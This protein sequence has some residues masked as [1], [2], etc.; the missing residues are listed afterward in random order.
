[1]IYYFCTAG[2][3]THG[4]AYLIFYLWC[5]FPSPVSHFLTGISFALKR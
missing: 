5:N 3:L 1:M 4:S 2:G